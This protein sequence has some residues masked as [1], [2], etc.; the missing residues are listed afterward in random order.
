MKGFYLERNNKTF[1][2]SKTSGGLHICCTRPGKPIYD[3]N[4][5]ISAKLNNYK[6]LLKPVIAQKCNQKRK[7]RL[8]LI[9]AKK[10]LAIK[11]I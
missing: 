10:Y 11:F 7:S 4:F 1:V 5:D 3:S 9:M 6:S 2:I 8:A